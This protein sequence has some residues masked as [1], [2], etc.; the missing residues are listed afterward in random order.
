M[1]KSLLPW[2]VAGALALASATVF[3]NFHTFEIQEIYSDANGTVQYIVLQESQGLD[4][5]N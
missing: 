3:A 1:N 4:H 5:E 2:P